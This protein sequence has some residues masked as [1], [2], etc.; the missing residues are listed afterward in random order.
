MLYRT[1]VADQ[2]GELRLMPDRAAPATTQLLDQGVRFVVAR[3]ADA[4]TV[5]Y[6]KTNTAV[7]AD[8]FAWSAGLAAPCTLTAVPSAATVATLLV[9][10]QVVAWADIDVQSQLVSGAVTTLASCATKSL[11][12]GLVG[13]AGLGDDRL[14]YVDG[15]P[16]GAYDGTLRVTRVGAAGAAG[17]GT[18]I[19]HDVAAVF[20]AVAPSAVVYTVDTG[21]AADGVYVYA[22]S[23][24]TD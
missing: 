21:T 16:L 8:L 20:A 6:S 12:T 3:S 18:P 2:V 11:G 5:I 9:G 1:S 10:N 7:G 13:T 14:L 4:G 22:G 24:L 19:A 15:A 17:E 23:L